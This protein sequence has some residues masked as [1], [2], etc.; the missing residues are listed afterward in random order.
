MANRTAREAGRLHQAAL[1]AAR[2]VY[3]QARPEAMG[4]RLAVSARLRDPR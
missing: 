3:A 1:D 2:V 4:D